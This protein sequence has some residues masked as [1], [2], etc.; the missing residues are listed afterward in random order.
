MPDELPLRHRLLVLVAVENHVGDAEG[1]EDGGE[2]VVAA[3]CVR[4]KR[5]RRDRREG[6]ALRVGLAPKGSK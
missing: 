2:K 4:A 1:L 3:R 6:H 5:R